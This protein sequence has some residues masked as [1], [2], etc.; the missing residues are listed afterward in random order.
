MQS[1]QIK[2]VYNRQIISSI[3]IFAICSIVWGHCNA[4]LEAGTVQNSYDMLLQSFAIQLGKMGTI[5]FFIISGLLIQPKINSYT[6]FGFLRHRFYSTLLPWMIFVVLLVALI[7]LNDEPSRAIIRS[8]TF[9]EYLHLTCQL[10][11]NVV[12]YHSYWFI[13]VFFI[14]MIT[15]I[16]FKKYVFNLKM[17]FILGLFTLFYGINL[18][19][20]W[21][22]VHH[23]K[24]FVGYV[25]FVWLGIQISKHHLRF[26]L[27]LDKIGWAV[28]SFILMIAI[29]ASGMEGAELTKIGCA[30]PYASIRLSNVIAS[31]LLFICLFKAGEVKAINR[32]IPDR[33]VYGIYLLHTALLYQQTMLVKLFS[34]FFLLPHKILPLIGAQV[35]NFT[36]IL[37]TSVILVKV[38]YNRKAIA[39]RSI[40]GIFMITTQTRNAFMMSTNRLYRR[41]KFDLTL[42]IYFVISTYR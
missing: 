4:G 32:L 28:L 29:V 11:K 17:G 34:S 20:G 2:P 36:F 19:Y 5:L 9:W 21:I 10:L 7:I 25:F 40:I 13:L 22:S 33:I 35:L 6:V 3:R 1:L 26:I 31:L 37:T 23:T 24:A 8:G 16:L 42:S 27:W 15:L 41:I 18:H 30:D 38:F 12:L 39:V 14:S